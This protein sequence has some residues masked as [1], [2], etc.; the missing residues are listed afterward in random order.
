MTRAD[1]RQLSAL[2]ESFINDTIKGLDRDIALLQKRLFNELFDKLVV[3]LKSENGKLKATDP[4]NFKSINRLDELMK[5]FKTTFGNEI[6]KQ[7]G[8]KLLKTI[9]FTDDY[10]RDGLNVSEQSFASMKESTKWVYERIGIT[11][12]GQIIAGSYLDNIASMPEV[13]TAVRNYITNNVVNGAGV[14]SFQKGFR[15]LIEGTKDLP[16]VVTRYHQQF[17]RDIFNQVD[18]AVNSTYAKVNDLKYFVYAGTAIETTRCFCRKRID[19]VFS[20][21]DADKWI[22]DVTPPAYNKNTPYRPLIDMG[23]FNCRHYPEYID[24]ATAKM[25]GY[26][27]AKAND[28]LNEEC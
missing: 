28:V 27:E 6:A 5:E 22:D 18:N 23:G 21:D 13:Q 15:Q 3:E 4:N 9:Q 14:S 24:E 1:Q 19:M 17:S 25:L 8:E 10:F 26:S 16:G 2:K 20:V 11:E 7:I 12:S